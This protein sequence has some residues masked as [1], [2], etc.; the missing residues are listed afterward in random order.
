M[1]E[2]S[3]LNVA[4]AGLGIGLDVVGAIRDYERHSR[5]VTLRCIRIACLIFGYTIFVLSFHNSG[6][7]N[8]HLFL[9][10]VAF[11]LMLTALNMRGVYDFITRA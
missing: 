2:L 8:G 9:M 11:T 10:K 3:W 7:S 6:M 4:L 1:D 5:Y